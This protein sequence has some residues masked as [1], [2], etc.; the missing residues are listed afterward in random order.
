MENLIA[1]LFLAIIAL[2]LIAVIIWILAKQ[3]LKKV[4]AIGVT[5]CW[6][7]RLVVAVFRLINSLL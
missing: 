1:A 3:P 7:Y 4:E 6:M 2:F 5:V